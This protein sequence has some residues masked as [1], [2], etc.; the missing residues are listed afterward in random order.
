M[1]YYCNPISG[2]CRC[3]DRIFSIIAKQRLG[4]NKAHAADEEEKKMQKV[5]NMSWAWRIMSE[6]IVDMEHAIFSFS[7]DILQF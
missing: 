3:N 1:W 5:I 7:S 6:Q 4:E 2:D